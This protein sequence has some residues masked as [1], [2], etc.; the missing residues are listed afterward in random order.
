[1]LQRN[2]SKLPR[3]VWGWEGILRPE[4]AL[5]RGLRVTHSFDDANRGPN[6]KS[7]A[8]SFKNGDTNWKSDSDAIT[9]CTAN[10]QVARRTARTEQY[11][12]NNKRHYNQQCRENSCHFRLFSC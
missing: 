9:N 11:R 4:H 12:S 10:R 1:M 3:Q 5:L 6:P 2:R 8:F 7:H